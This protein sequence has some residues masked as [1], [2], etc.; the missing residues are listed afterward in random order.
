MDLVTEDTDYLCNKTPISFLKRAGL[1]TG[2]PGVLCL[3][4]S[5]L[6]LIT[7]LI[8]ICKKKNNFLLRLFF[9]LSVDVTISHTVYSLCLILYTD[10]KNGNM[11][12]F[13]EA[14]TSYPTM[15]EFLFII[16]INCILLHKVYSSVRKPLYQFKDSKRAEAVFVAV[17]FLMPL[18]I[19]FIL[20][21]IAKEPR[22]WAGS[23]G[24]Y[25]PKPYQGSDC[26]KRK[27][28][29]LLFN[30]I[31][32]YIPVVIELVLSI[33]C[34]FTLLI[35]G[36][37]LFNKRFLRARMKLVLKEIGLLLGYLTS[38]CIIRIVIEIMNFVNKD[39]NDTIMLIT[40][41]LYPLNR[42]TIPIS[43]LVYVCFVLG[44][45]QRS[46]GQ[47][48]NGYTTGIQTIRP[49]SRISLPSDTFEHLPNF[50]SRDSLL[51]SY[52]PTENSRLLPNNK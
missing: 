3:A 15:V 6:G 28:Y 13:I 23:E 40:F 41:A 14:V 52:N 7:E 10:P 21:L 20:M 30:L 47:G 35:W 22:F 45:S 49:S 37:W 46:K 51:G 50:L 25:F 31:P 8:F 16:S 17:H 1:A 48:N 39:K 42:V 9:Y 33:L 34:I 2:V 27:E 26:K 24:C 11:C 18:I 38:Y 36:C 4:I 32:E 5:L 12:A 19:I 44:C 29:Q 43:F